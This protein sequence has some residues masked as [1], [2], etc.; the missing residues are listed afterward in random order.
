MTTLADLETA[1]EARTEAEKQE[2]LLFLALFLN[3]SRGL[4]AACGSQ[5][6][7]L[8]FVFH[9]GCPPPHGWDFCDIESRRHETESNAR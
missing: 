3:T 1:A 8:P 5:R 6:G 2:L 9:V 7:G 4:L